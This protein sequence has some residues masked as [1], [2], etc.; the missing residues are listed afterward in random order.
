MFYNLYSSQLFFLIEIVWPSKI[1]KV[2]ASFQSQNSLLLTHDNTKMLVRILRC[3]VLYVVPKLMQR[4]DCRLILI[5]FI[6]YKSFPNQGG[7][8]TPLKFLSFAVCKR[9]TLTLNWNR[10]VVFPSFTLIVSE[11]IQENNNHPPPS[12]A[13]GSRSKSG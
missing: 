4:F 13:F 1:S 2:I 9:F 11:T 5:F 6:W 10:D 3:H 12:Q 8:S 7:V